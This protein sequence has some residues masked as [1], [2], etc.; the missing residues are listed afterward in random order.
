LVAEGDAEAQDGGARIVDVLIQLLGPQ[1][2]PRA[3]MGRR[4]HQRRLRIGIL[5]IFEDHVRF[6]NDL[7]AV[8]Q[9]RDDGAAVELEIPGLLVL[10]GAQHEVAVF[11]REPFLGEADAHLL[12]AQRHVIM[13]ERQ[14]RPPPSIQ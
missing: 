10:A 6:R 11:P 8:D 1:S 2:H 4:G 9:R 3:S 13:I 14:H 7:V 12:G 5:E